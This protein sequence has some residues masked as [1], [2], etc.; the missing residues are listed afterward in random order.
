MSLWSNLQR[1]PRGGD[2]WLRGMIMVKSKTLTAREET[3]CRPGRK[4]SPACFFIPDP[5]YTRPDTTPPVLYRSA[6]RSN[7]KI[8]SHQNSQKKF[9]LNCFSFDEVAPCTLLS[10][11]G[12]DKHFAV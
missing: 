1:Q 4:H 11:R 10:A 2:A 9:L 12:C 5:R 8:V 7:A 6:A 3:T